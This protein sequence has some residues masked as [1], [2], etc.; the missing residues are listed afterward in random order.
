MMLKYN[1]IVD[2]SSN[3]FAT[4]KNILLAHMHFLW[5]ILSHRSYTSTPEQLFHIHQHNPSWPMCTTEYKYT[6][7]R[8]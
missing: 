2:K 3:N 1:S 6:F 8:Q 7:I 4:K 5:Y